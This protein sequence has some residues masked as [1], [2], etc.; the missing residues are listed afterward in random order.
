MKRS[1]WIGALLLALAALPARAQQAS[2]NIAAA[3]QITTG[4]ELRL[5]GQHRVEPDL[6]L[7]IFDPGFRIGNLYADLNV[8]RRNDRLVIG[9]GLLRLDAWQAAGLTWSLEAGDTWNRPA[10]QD[11]GFSNLFAPQVTFQGASIRGSNARTTLLVS[12]GRVT[13][14]RNL[15]GTDT[16][17]IGQQLYQVSVSHRVNDRI[18]VSARGVHVR[19]GVM[20]LYSALTERSTDVGGG[21]RV[22]P[23]AAL[24]LMADGGVTSFVR[25]GTS[26]TE[27]APSAL[28]G[29]IW[30]LSRGW[31]QVNAQRFSIGHY[32]VSNFPYSDRSGVFAAGEVDLW[33]SA[34]IFAG[35]EYAKS[36]LSPNTA[37]SA[38]AGV[39]PGT[40]SRAYGGLRLS[41]PG[42]SMVTVRVEGGGR[43]IRPSKFSSGFES[44]TGVVTTEWHGRFQTVNLF[45]RYERRSNVDPNNSGSSFTQHDASTQVYVNLNKGR[46]LFALGFFSR[47]AD[48]TGDGQTFW[49]VGGGGQTPLGPLYLRLEGT[50][51]RT[52]DWELQT[53]TTRQSLAAGLSGRIADRTYLSVDCY[54][55]HSPFALSTSGSPWMTRTMIRIT[56]A[57]P[58]GAART[59]NAPGRPSHGG[60]AGT[61]SGVV[62]ADWN[63]NGV[64]DA[65]DTPVSGIT[66]SIATMGTVDTGREGTF[67][68]GAVPVGPQSVSLDIASVP[69]DYDPPA[70]ERQVITVARNQ[71][72]ATRFALLPLGALQGTVMQDVDGDGTLSAADTPI[73]KAVLV[74]DDGARTE[75]TR[76]GRFRFDSVRMG[77]HTITLLMG[78]LPDG[79]QLAGEPAVT[80]E[81]GKGKAPNAMVYLVK[82]EKRPEVR[83]V[84]PPKK[85]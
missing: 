22:R 56:R 18:D 70:D 44:D 57:M 63:G 12:A 4:D 77:A 52:R 80:V 74:L 64:M 48:R 43:D 2:L 49:H 19:S 30:A 71:T 35:A 61:I 37:T 14:Q 9:R 17:T 82:L 32:P 67:S 60:P 10:V 27:Y 31:I 69:A 66:V 59:V 58:F 13:A 28:V 23:V 5:G 40:Y 7:Q 65:D 34:R 75:M 3:A 20:P 6:S 16:R 25:R 81:L 72:A 1:A 41:L 38:T 54:V 62:F 45:A 73:D 26:V 46:Q 8:T 24:Q 51:G 36:N 29:S 83:K 39:P 79:A 47:R 21:L 42:S 53:V 33:K 68:F 11:F 78:S 84:F 50:V 15:F 85:K 55:D 76:D